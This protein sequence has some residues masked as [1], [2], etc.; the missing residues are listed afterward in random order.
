LGDAY[1]QNSPSFNG[2]KAIFA[3]Q[4][5]LATEDVTQR[6]L[7]REA[8]SYIRILE[9]YVRSPGHGLMRRSPNGD[10]NEQT[11]TGQQG[12]V[13]ETQLPI[14]VQVEYDALLALVE[15][16]RSIAAPAERSAL[17]REFLKRS[18]SLIRKYPDILRIWILRAHAAAFL[19]MHFEGYE[20]GQALERLSAGRA[21]DE[22]MRSALVALRSRGYLKDPLAGENFQES[23]AVAFG[24]QKIM[25]LP[26]P[27]GRFQMGSSNGDSN[28]QPVREVSLRRGFWMGQ[29]EVTQSQWQA[30]M[31]NNPSHFKG[32]DRPVEKVSWQ[33]AVEFCDRLTEQQRSA[34]RLPRGYVYRLPTEA[35]W[36]YAA[37]GGANGRNTEYA[38]GENLIEVAWSGLNSGRKTHPVGGKRANE[39]GLHDMSG[40]VWEWCHDWYQETYD[41]LATTDPSGPAIGS[42]RVFRGGSWGPGI[43]GC[44]VVSRARRSP[45]SSA[46]FLGFRVVLAPKIQ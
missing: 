14:A 6:A 12:E 43:R 36:E 25:L 17:L 42:S 40:N 33:D 21:P 19:E 26:I 41:G 45:T 18:D 34:G 38:G 5:F 24:N 20:A 13:A 3:Y 23:R 32:D 30:M 15:E 37:R 27:S 8:E 7:R 11:G 31:G 39:L 44:R 46:Y 10:S 29:T 2:E 35:E 1:R 28:E 22:A 9:H 16:S 4:K